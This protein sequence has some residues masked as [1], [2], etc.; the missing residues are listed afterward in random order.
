MYLLLFLLVSPAFGTSISAKLDLAR[1]TVSEVRDL[2][3]LLEVHDR[4]SDSLEASV[5]K[6]Q[7]LMVTLKGDLNKTLEEAHQI[8]DQARTMDLSTE[9]RSE[10]IDNLKEEIDLVQNWAN[11]AL[12]VSKYIDRFPAEYLEKYQ[13]VRNIFKTSLDDLN[14]SAQLAEP[15]LARRREEAVDGLQE[16]EEN[17][18][19]FMANLVSW[20]PV[21][22]ELQDGTR[23][24]ESYNQRKTDMRQT[25]RELRELARRTVSKERELKILLED[26]VQNNSTVLF[27]LYSH[28]MNELL[29]KTK[30]KLEES[31]EKYEL[32]VKT[33]ENLISFI[34]S[35]KIVLKNVWMSAGIRSLLEQG[36]SLE[37]SLNV[38]KDIL[39]YEIDIISSWTNSAKVAIKDIKNSPIVTLQIQPIRTNFE[40]GLNDLKNVNELFLAQPLKIFAE[41]EV[42]SL[43]AY[44]QLRRDLVHLADRTETEVRELKIVLEDLDT[45]NLS[46]L[47]EIKMTSMKELT[48][49][50]LGRLREAGESA[51]EALED[52]ADEEYMTEEINLIRSWTRGALVVKKKLD[53]YQH[54]KKYRSVRTIFKNRLDDLKTYAEQFVA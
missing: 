46:V 38:A 27:K 30:E 34:L 26:L 22:P 50:T 11:S 7:D 6:M 19:I 20:Q 2:K 36:D 33:F 40:N 23:Y 13:S 12:V 4:D 37:I 18:R 31:R 44:E 48:I 52:Q 16:T 39:S 24:L 35:Q 41:Q 14:N 42:D 28:K 43:S 51:I 3:M 32:A 5:G 25:R 49:E 54:L 21:V 1:R 45:G 8:L 53:Q 10:T 29:L 15:F 47:F 17:I 9:E